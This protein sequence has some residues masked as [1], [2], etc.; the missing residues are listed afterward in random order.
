M[1]QLAAIAVVVAV[2]AGC[3]NA[4]DPG[5]EPG[6]NAP[7]STSDTLGR[8]PQGGPDGTTPPA[9]C[10]GDDGRVLRP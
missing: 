1:R 5:L 6:S 3:V 2:A 10:V 9:G 7:A 8:C 4:Q